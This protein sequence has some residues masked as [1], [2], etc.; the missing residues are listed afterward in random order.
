MGEFIYLYTYISIHQSIHAYLYIDTHTYN[1][2]KYLFTEEC[3]A[4]SRSQWPQAVA[5]WEKLGTFG[6]AL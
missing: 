1:R 2:K 4:V 5:L 6:G 3:S